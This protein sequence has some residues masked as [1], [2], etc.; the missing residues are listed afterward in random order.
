MG[1]LRGNSTFLKS[2][3]SMGNVELNIFHY[4][5]IARSQALRRYFLEHGSGKARCRISKILIESRTLPLCAAG[6]SDSSRPAFSFLRPAL[7]TMAQWLT[8]GERL[9]WG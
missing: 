2:Y 9:E 3:H 5:L 4:S 7:E 1:S 8:R 6:S